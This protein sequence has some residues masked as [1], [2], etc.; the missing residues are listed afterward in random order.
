MIF[1]R[2]ENIQE[3]V[4]KFVYST[5]FEDFKAICEDLAQKKF[6]EMQSSKKKDYEEMC[7]DKAILNLYMSFSTILEFKVKNQE[8]MNKNKN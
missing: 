2:N 1:K 6:S 5:N 7:V 8:E 4:S 3:I